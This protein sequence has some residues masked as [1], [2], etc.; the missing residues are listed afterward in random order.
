[1]KKSVILI[2]LQSGFVLSFTEAQN[3]AK[4]TVYFNYDQYDLTADACQKLD[5]ICKLISE[6]GNQKL[7][8]SGFTDEDG[9]DDYNLT[10][11]K[12]RAEAVLNYFVKKGVSR[13]LIELKYFGKKLSVANNETESGKQK[14]R[15][16]EI[17]YGSA[18]PTFSKATQTFKVLTSREI[19]LTCKEGTKITFPKNAFRTKDGKAFNGVADIEVAEFYKKSDMLLNKL[20]TTSDKQLLETGGMVYIDAKSG[21]DEL[22]LDP[23]TTYRIKMANNRKGDFGLFYGDTTGNKIDWVP[24]KSWS[25]PDNV[26]STISWTIYSDKTIPKTIEQ[27]V[28]KRGNG[29]Y[30]Y[31]NNILDTVNRGYMRDYART[32]T[33]T[34]SVA[35]EYLTASKLGWINCDRFYNAPQ[36]TGLFVTLDNDSETSIY[37]IFKSINAVMQYSDKENNVYSFYNVPVGEDVTIVAFSVKGDKVYYASEDAKITLLRKENL[38]LSAI[39][40]NDFDQMIAAVNRGK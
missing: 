10:L 23:T 1:M 29:V 40:H 39:T 6:H 21:D 31:F 7:T 27:Q 36:K 14:N 9:S 25:Q 2:L 32:P 16:V 24:A 13:N 30:Y 15:R 34:D 12:Q 17:V 11:S 18:K 8:I 33:K 38:S 4:E 3:P 22:D 26:Y 20:S 35:N 19:T 5:G 28:Q 37:L